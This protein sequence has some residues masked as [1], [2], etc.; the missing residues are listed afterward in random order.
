[1]KRIILFAITFLA[2][3]W[4]VRG[5][6]HAEWATYLEGYEIIDIA[7]AG[8]YL[9]LTD[10]KEVIKFDKNTAAVEFY[11]LDD[12]EKSPDYAITSIAC[13]KN[14]LPWFAATTVGILKMDE[15]DKWILHS[16]VNDSQSD[17]A[18]HI[19]ISDNDAVWTWRTFPVHDKTPGPLGSIFAGFE[20]NRI[21]T[22]YEGNQVDTFKLDGRISS[23]AEDKDGN[24]WISEWV[25]DSTNTGILPPSPFAALVKYDGENWTT[26]YCPEEYVGTPWNLHDITF[27]ETGNI[28]MGGGYGLLGGRSRLIQFN[29]S[30]WQVYDL[31][32][33]ARWM[34]SLALQEDGVIWI[35]SSDIGLMKFRNSQW[36][37]YDTE[38]SEPHSG[39]I[40]CIFI[41]EDGTKWI[42]TGNGLAAF[43]ENG[44]NFSE[45]AAGSSD[46]VLATS[47]DINSEAMKEVELFPNPTRDFTTLNIKE[48]I[49]YSTVDI[50]NFQ[51]QKI[52]SFSINNKQSQL[53]VS[54]L[55][56][57]VYLVRINSRQ[58][59]ILKRLIKQ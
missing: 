4:T 47:K 23:V 15:D 29:Q 32:E 54:Q 50:L 40:N 33:D 36:T 52:K 9:W 7:V 45:E 41:D 28:W 55:S 17:L 22:R 19:F 59:Y 24:L 39:D 16:Q 25:W 26:H 11:S 38:H 58:N 57:G 44:A 18:T 37:V 1:M 49:R 34:T 51:G 56:P 48:D 53:D 20:G 12:I 46:I 6:N 43:N 21:L 35:G 42:G 10:G 14:G 2:G 27:D 3:I 13:A 31:P 5:Q 30:D 8:D